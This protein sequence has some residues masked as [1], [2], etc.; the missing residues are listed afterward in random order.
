MSGVLKGERPSH[1]G[2]DSKAVA[3]GLDDDLWKLCEK[4]WGHEPQH[5]PTMA[6]VLNDKV[7]ATIRTQE[8][9]PAETPNHYLPLTMSPRLP[10]GWLQNT[11]PVSQRTCYVSLIPRQ[12]ISAY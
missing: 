2:P 1:P 4:C 3:R 5:R 11:D 8:A 6:E 7:F 9:Q 10:D 12:R